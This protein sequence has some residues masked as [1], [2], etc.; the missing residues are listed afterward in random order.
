M[1]DAFLYISSYDTDFYDYACI[2]LRFLSLLVYVCPLDGGF[3]QVQPG[4]MLLIP[5]MDGL[6]LNLPNKEVSSASLRLKDIFY[7]E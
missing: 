3:R 4:Q 6:S 7:V 2:Q 5:P 1:E